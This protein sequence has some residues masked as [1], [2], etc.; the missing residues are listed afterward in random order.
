M[1]LE[2]A[3]HILVSV[4]TISIAFT[5]AF[6]GSTNFDSA[7]ATEF[8]KILLTVGLGFVLHELAHRY[9]ARRYGAWAEYRAWTL[10]LILAIVMALFVGFVFAAPGATYIFGPHLNQE[11]N[12]KIALA[13][14]LTNL[15]LAAGFLLVGYT[16]PGL[17]GLAQLG[18]SVNLF[19]GAFNLIPIFPLD[20]QKIYVWSVKT[21][22]LISAVMVAGLLLVWFG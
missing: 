15:L 14:P 19:L 3:S 9:L 13:G 4:V 20:G 7:F 10:G 22:A 6:T 17:T 11:K 8:T 21:W 2:E 12:G 5:I 1:K 16:L 18:A